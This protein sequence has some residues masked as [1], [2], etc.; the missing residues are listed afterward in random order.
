MEIKNTKDID[1]KKVI[2]AVA[3]IDKAGNAAWYKNSDGE[4][5]ADILETMDVDIKDIALITVE[6]ENG[7]VVSYLA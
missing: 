7:E 4:T 5:V 2:V 1:L 3:L 6:Y